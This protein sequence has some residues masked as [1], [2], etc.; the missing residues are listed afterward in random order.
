M[1]KA[2]FWNRCRHDRRFF[3]KK[4]I[5]IRVQLEDGSY[6]M[7]PFIPNPEQKLVIDWMEEQE[8]QQ[9]PVRFI[10]LKARQLGMTTLAMA[11]WFHLCVFRDLIRC[12]VVGHRQ[13][14]T[15]KISEMPLLMNSNLPEPIKERCAAKKVRLN[16]YWENGSWLELTTQGGEEGGRGATPTAVHA[17]ELSSWDI[18]RVQSEAEKVLQGYFSP[19][20]IVAGTYLGCESTAGMAAG[21]MYDRFIDTHTGPPGLWKSFFFSWQN[22]PK[23]CLKSTH[24]QQEVDALMKVHYKKGNAAA[25]KKIADKLGYTQI[26][27]ERAIQYDLLVGEV[28]WAMA[29]VR[30]MKGDLRRF[31]QEFPLSWQD[32][33]VAGGRP[34]FD[35][36][37]VSCWDKTEPPETTIMGSHLEQKGTNISLHPVGSDWTIYIPPRDHHEYVVGVD[38][39]SGVQDGDYSTAVVFDRHTREIVAQM[40]AKLP[41]DQTADQAVLAAKWYNSA[42]LIPEINNHGYACVSRILELHYPMH[43][44][45]PNRE[46]SPQT[47]WSE[48]FGFM[49]TRST[50]Q[51][52]IDV[53]AQAVREDSITVW[54]KELITEMRTFVYDARGR[55][56]HMSGRHSDAIIA[57]CLCLYADAIKA[58]PHPLHHEIEETDYA[59]ELDRWRAGRRS[60]KSDKGHPRLGTFA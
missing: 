28:L 15:R 34:V 21:S 19:V 55:A 4:C 25:A 35:Q 51:M 44:R 53:L 40:Y 12:Q 52:I 57:T 10:I 26:W 54:S 31:D 24:E 2:E 22:V 11:I 41:P 48:A 13:E 43:R 46:L 36:N 49:T 32:A 7:M 59:S 38:C 5:R 14:D 37:T 23:Y 18:L 60:G 47:P 8:R 17:T 1:T 29:K 27:F 16:L 58:P 20:N 3:F 33:F 45:H 6:R 50:R 39:A 30:E 9:L 42:Y 56:D